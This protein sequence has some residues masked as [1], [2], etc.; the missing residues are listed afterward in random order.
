[1]W[2][3]K[4][5][6]EYSRNTKNGSEHV[7]RVDKHGKQKGCPHGAKLGGKKFYLAACTWKSHL[8]HI[9]CY[10]DVSLCMNAK[11]TQCDLQQNLR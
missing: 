1:M 6:F 5:Q 8:Y 4:K 11:V 3:K 7:S 9:W 10:L 2:E